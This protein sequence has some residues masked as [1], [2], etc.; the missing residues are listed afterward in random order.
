MVSM[1]P[2]TTAPRPRRT[3]LSWVRGGGLSTFVFFVPLLL[4]LLSPRIIMMPVTP[5]SSGV[6]I[7]NTVGPTTVKFTISRTTAATRAKAPNFY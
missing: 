4:S 5:S 1:T 6:E 3:P 2:P 7:P